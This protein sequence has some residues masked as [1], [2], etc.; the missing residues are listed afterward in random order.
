MVHT[1][2]PSTTTGMVA[3]VR[4]FSGTPSSPNAVARGSPPNA[5]EMSAAIAATASVLS[6]L[7]SRDEP[8]AR[9]RSRRVTTSLASRA[10]IRMRTNSAATTYST[11]VASVLIVST[12]G[13]PSRRAIVVW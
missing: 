2:S 7:S 13:M 8:P 12:S 4:S 1:T 10:E 11:P 6:A 5:W 9:I 3:T